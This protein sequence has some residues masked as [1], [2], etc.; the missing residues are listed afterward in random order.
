MLKRDELANPQSCLNRAINHEMIFVLLARDEAAPAAIREWIQAR[1]ASGKNADGD[2]QVTE[3]LTCAHVMEDQR[4]GIKL[5][6]AGNERRSAKFQ[7]VTNQEP[8]Y[9]IVSDGEGAEASVIAG[10][11]LQESVHRFMCVCGK[12]WRT[13]DSSTQ[14]DIEEIDDGDKWSRDESGKPF[15]LTW[16]HETGRLTI[17]RL[18]GPTVNALTANI[19]RMWTLIR[20][21][22][23]N[24][25]SQT[26]YAELKGSQSMDIPCEFLALCEFAEEMGVKLP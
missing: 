16:P 4:S 12:P 11:D 23:L 20:A 26:S 25:T 6:L 22:V 9:V 8:Q 13:C 3:A 1:I 19:E 7:V 24:E 17:Y 21:F 10:E 15:S 5:H 14:H 2:A 18:S